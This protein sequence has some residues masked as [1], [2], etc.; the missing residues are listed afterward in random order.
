MVNADLLP[1]RVNVWEEVWTL[2]TLVKE[3]RDY[4]GVYIITFVLIL[5]LISLIYLVYTSSCRKNKY[6]NIL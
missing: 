2:S 1:E 4:Y 6:E 3:N 5:A